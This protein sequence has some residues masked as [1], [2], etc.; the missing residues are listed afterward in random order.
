M[1]FLVRVYSLF[2]TLFLLFVVAPLFGYIERASES[3]TLFQHLVGLEGVV[4]IERLKSSHWQ[5]KYQLTVEQPVDW[6]NPNGKK[7]NQRIFLMNVAFDRPTTLVTEGYGAAYVKNPNYKE[8]LSTLLN[9]NLV[10]VE[11]RFF[12]E[13]TPDEREWKFLSAENSA[14][15]LHRIREILAPLY[16][17]RW[18]ATGI[19]KGG[20]QALIY[21]AY[22][23][24][25]VDITVPYVAPLCKGR[26]D[27]R[28]EP[29]LEQVGTPQERATLAAF[30][31]RVLQKRGELAPKFDSLCRAKKY[32]F[33]LPLEEIY[34]YSVLEF[35]FAFWQW[36]SDI[37]KVPNGDASIDEIFKY[38]MTISSPDYFVEESSYTPF[39]VQAY[40]ELGYYGY[41]TKPFKGLLK[42]KNSR[43]Y[44]S[45][46][47]VP[48]EVRGKFNKGLYKKLKRFV[49]TTNNK[50]LFIYGE[51]DPWS[52]VMVNEPYGKNVVVVTDPKGS[53]RARIS[54][55]PVE[56][57]EEATAILEGWLKN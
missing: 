30:Q 43:G 39:F 4:K 41:D 54:T 33:A 47:F 56:M 9:S 37:G 53:H 26:S 27:G 51:Y 18:I 42:I 35:P 36:G 49:S 20:Q 50:M 38:W 45:T 10:V 14:K 28:H 15:D 21:T 48:K 24:Q 25:D 7:F 16:R 11:H 34:D 40:K 44:L 22:F 8:E 2:F 6:N 19:S 23:P 46:L 13:S 3:D 1:R 5:E 32:T 52:A 31:K 57:R 29:F 55:L 17:E 12:L